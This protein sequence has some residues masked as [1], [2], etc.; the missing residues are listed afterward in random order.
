M[1]RQKNTHKNEQYA[2]KIALV[3]IIFIAFLALLPSIS[4]ESPYLNDS[5]EETGDATSYQAIYQ[6]G[7]LYPSIELYEWKFM[8][9]GKKIADVQLLENSDRCIT[10]CYAILQVGLYK[11]K[12]NFF[13]DIFFN[14]KVGYEDIQETDEKYDYK[15]YIKQIT[16][17]K[18][19]RTNSYYNCSEWFEKEQKKLKEGEI[20]PAPNQ[21]TD[22]ELQSEQIE[23]NITEEY[24]EEYQPD[25]VL[26]HGVYYFKIT[27]KKQPYESV[28]WIPQLFDYKI[29][30]LA[31]W[32]ASAPFG[33]GSDGDLI[34]TTTTKS[35]GTMVLNQDYT[36]S[37]NILRLY[38]NRV[39]QFN[40]MV[41]GAGTTLT[42]TNTSGVAMYIE[43]LNQA[44]I[45]GLINLS[46][47]HSAGQSNENWS[48]YG[49]VID[50]PGV[51]LGGNGGGASGGTGWNGSGYGGGGIG[52][53]VQDDGLNNCDDRCNGKTSGYGGNGSI[54]IQAGSGLSAST[55]G[56][57]GRGDWSADGLRSGGGGGMIRKSATG[58]A[59]SGSGGSTYGNNGGS[60]INSGATSYLAT[61][62]GGS[63][64]Q[65]GKSGL[66]FY[67]ASQIINFTG[68]INTSG[69]NGQ[70]GGAG[71]GNIGANYAYCYNWGG[72]GAGGSGGGNAGNISFVYETL[73]DTGTKS[74]NKGS[75][76]NGC[77]G[78]SG[79]ANN[80][81][82]QTAPSGTSGSSGINGTFEGNQIDLGIDI[83]LN[84]PAN[85]ASL[86]LNQNA[87]FNCT[88]DAGIKNVTNM[89]FY[90][91]SVANFT[92]STINK[93]NYTLIR[94]LNITS[95]GIYYWTC[96]AYNSDGDYN[97]APE[98]YFTIRP[99]I[100]DAESYSN[101]SYETGSANFTINVI[102][103]STEYSDVNAWLIYD[104][105]SHYAGKQLATN[106]AQ[107]NSSITIPLTAS[108][109]NQNKTFYWRILFTEEGTGDIVNVTSDIRS[110]LVHP[111]FLRICN[112]TY[113]ISAL[114]FTIRN[115]L[116]NSEVNATLQSSFIKYYLSDG[117]GSTYRNYSYQ[118]LIENTSRYSFCINPSDR[119]YITDLQADYDATGY[120]PRTK[121]LIG[122]SLSNSTTAQDLYLLSDD[123]AVKFFIRVIN[124]MSPV[125]DAY[126]T[127]TKYFPGEGIYKTIGIR[128][129]DSNGMFIEYLE[130][131][132][133]YKFLVYKDG[134]LLGTFERVSICES[135]PCEMTLQLA[136]AEEVEID[137]YEGFN[138][139]FAQNISYSLTYNKTTKMVRFDFIDLTGLAQYF[140]LKVSYAFGND[141]GGTICEQTIYSTAG[142]AYCNLT[143]YS[144]NF[145]ARAVIARSPE[146]LIKDL[147]II[148]ND[149][150]DALGNNGLI[151]SL[152]ILVTIGLVGVWN[153]PVGIVLIFF[154]MF[155][156]N[157][158]GFASLSMGTLGIVFILV[159]LILWRMKS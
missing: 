126:V 50:L 143:G 111:I 49:N 113:N 28:D 42:T 151:V 75:G 30:E 134:T 158:L 86:N 94:T 7:K 102:Y 121:Y 56:C 147:F 125:E 76:G 22:C 99:F 123:D 78:A 93:T 100:V 115:E 12:K 133:N 139:V 67:L 155:A 73:I 14:S 46:G 27:G 58:T 3:M 107:F 66:Y 118:N 122:A 150:K 124:G 141:T 26:Q 117:D 90:I 18:I 109:A 153:P 96:D 41:L 51:G 79:L 8:G 80:F 88:A 83:T 37:G 59:Q 47:V 25:K 108:Q 9:I 13:N 142:T 128:Q 70:N 31:W 48:I 34:F 62:G 64:G 2:T 35:Y 84:S 40:N 95:Y 144:G 33:D 44:N 39:Y 110:Q 15:I 159:L 52:G 10:D 145:R 114:N 92:N 130:L 24:W 20:M 132:K 43:V 17:K 106:Y 60:P 135:A 146:M 72:A 105:T 74:M 138:D 98:R 6:E 36:V 101:E 57:Y 120:A 148:I 23:D 137:L 16:N 61:G 116:N 68:I 104:G 19:W 5:Q 21:E 152:I 81:G 54:N 69:I 157:L 82:T 112:A 77:A 87:T 131:D 85:G 55:S 154:A 29:E 156:L 140:K 32:N 89:T 11:N 91:N 103:N 136:L 149:L 129:T 1:K 97:I 4:A 127:I 119:T 38:T 45:S 65:A 71:A 63:G 53:R